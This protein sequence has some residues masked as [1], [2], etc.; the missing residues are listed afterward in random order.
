MR[1]VDINTK[2]Y[3]FS[4]KDSANGEA[5]ILLLD[6]SYVKKPQ[7]SIKLPLDETFNYSIQGMN[8]SGL[9]NTDTGDTLINILDVGL[10]NAEG[11][12]MTLEATGTGFT[13][14]TTGW[15][16]SQQ[17]EI[18][19]SSETDLSSVANPFADLS[20]GNKIHRI[21]D[22][23]TELFVSGQPTEYS[24]ALRPLINGAPVGD[25]IFGRV[26]S[27]GGGVYPDDRDFIDQFKFNIR[28]YDGAI[29]TDLTEPTEF[30]AEW[31]DPYDPSV[32]IRL[33]DGFMTGRGFTRLDIN[34]DP[35][36]R[37]RVNEVRSRT[38]NINGRQRIRVL[39]PTGLGGGD[40][41][42]TGVTKEDRLITEK[43]L[44]FEYIVKSMQIKL[45]SITGVSTDN[46]AII[47]VYQKGREALAAVQEI[48][49]FSEST[50]TTEL[51][52]QDLNFE[53][54]KSQGPLTIVV[55]AFDPDGV[56]PNNRASISGTLTVRGRPKLIDKI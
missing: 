5:K 54:L 30:D 18:V 43:D 20:S 39:D 55:D 49:A 28:V 56:S 22:T 48:E 34:G 29:A 32:P 19:I 26:Q 4:V 47:R 8:N 1:I 10:L 44:P 16:S 35:I 40:P 14:H 17:R 46:G 6:E 53:I 3:V 11:G 25:T 31:Y 23:H 2:Q 37:Y 50:I 24:V 15:P 13:V 42:A 7:I 38:D 45:D 9:S 33:D 36:G 51:T 27:G 12:T 21:T 52:T 41:I